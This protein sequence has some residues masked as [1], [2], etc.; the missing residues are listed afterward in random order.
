VKKAIIF[1][2]NSPEWIYSFYAIWEHSAVVIPVDAMSTPKEL[3]YILSDSKPELIFFSENKQQIV[4]LA[5]EKSNISDIITINIDKISID[6]SKQCYAGLR[7]YLVSEIAVIIY[8]SG[9]TG[10]PKGVML[11]YNNIE[12]NIKA[13][14]DFIPIYT[15]QDRN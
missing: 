1:A 2:D 15:P 7:E 8:T 12:T 11:S 5:I 10:K 14:T 6:K 3:A 9:T 4:D 13:V